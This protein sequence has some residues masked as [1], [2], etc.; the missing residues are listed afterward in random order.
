MKSL[1]IAMATAV[2]LLI[3]AVAMAAEEGKPKEKSKGPKLSLIAQTMLRIDHIKGAVEGL[4]LSDGQ[5]EKLGKVRDE[6]EVKK[7][8]IIEKIADLLTDEQKQIG[9]D[10]ME[11][12]KQSGKKGREVL[13]IAGGVPQA[14]GRAEAEDGADRKRTS[15]SCERHDE[16]SHGS[17]DSRTERETPAEDRAGGEEGQKA[18]R[19]VGFE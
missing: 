14:H 13:P 19:E 12:A 18:G 2:A 7:N 15:G 6:F 10:A 11:S 17:S 16:A 1:K 9:K 8:A 3:T 4:D 5:K